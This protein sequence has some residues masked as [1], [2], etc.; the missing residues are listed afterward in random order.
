MPKPQFYFFYNQASSF[1]HLLVYLSCILT[2]S[3]KVRRTSLLIWVMM[4]VSKWKKSGELTKSG[5]ITPQINNILRWAKWIFFVIELHLILS[6][7]VLSALYSTCQ[8]L[9]LRAAPVSL[10]RRIKSMSF[11]GHSWFICQRRLVAP[12]PFSYLG[13]LFI[14]ELLHYR[15]IKTILQ[16]PWQN[17]LCWT[18]YIISLC[19]HGKTGSIPVEGQLYVRQVAHTVEEMGHLTFNPTQCQIISYLIVGKSDRFEENKMF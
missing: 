12:P 18:I 5:T 8:H 15:D 16:K 10:H 19:C 11:Y 14:Y 9:T 17:V 6:C 3:K 1:T 13:M 7:L 4:W 2:L